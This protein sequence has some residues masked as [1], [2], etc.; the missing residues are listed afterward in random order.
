MEVQSKSLEIR[1]QIL[2]DRIEKFVNT[3]GVL[4]QREE[5]LIV[6]KNDPTNPLK[7]YKIMERR[8]TQDS[9]AFGPQ[10][11]KWDDIIKVRLIFDGC[12]Y[13]HDASKA[14]WG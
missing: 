8:G 3:G 5:N 4:F 1:N 2:Q 7:D 9:F 12:I 14:V 10:G 6:F 13:I 11:S